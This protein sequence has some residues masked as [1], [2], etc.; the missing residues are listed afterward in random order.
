M[1][2]VGT[3]RGNRGLSPIIGKFPLLLHG[4]LLYCQFLMLNCFTF[5]GILDL[6]HTFNGILDVNHTFNGI[7]DVNTS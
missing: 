7:L 5:N 1:D 2:I 4:V 6:N 3:N